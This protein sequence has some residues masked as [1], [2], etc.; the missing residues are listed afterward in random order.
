MERS[1]SNLAGFR[2][3]SE[4]NPI[5]SIIENDSNLV[6]WSAA[7]GVMVLENIKAKQNLQA[8]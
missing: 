6:I 1:L 3:S 8:K 5:V 7:A 4:I 2:V